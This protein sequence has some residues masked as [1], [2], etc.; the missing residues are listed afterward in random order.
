MGVPSDPRAC[1]L[2]WQ[3]VRIP[4]RHQLCQRTFYTAVV[5]KIATIPV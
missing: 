3:K 2:S 1:Y 4:A 5:T